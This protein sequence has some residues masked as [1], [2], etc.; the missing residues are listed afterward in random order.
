[1][2][3]TQAT[4]R[5][6]HRPT[7]SHIRAWCAGVAPVVVVFLAHL[8][9]ASMNKGGWWLVDLFYAGYM[10]LAILSGPLMFLPIG[11]VTGM[12]GI[13]VLFGGNWVL[14]YT[15]QGEKPWRTI[16]G[17]STAYC[18]V[19]STCLWAFLLSVSQ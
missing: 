10:T 5:H 13:L 7:D 6:E 17:L 15:R 19:C 1:M 18:L 9:Q 16:L 14:L 4:L 2:T 11:G 3:R 8:I 12:A